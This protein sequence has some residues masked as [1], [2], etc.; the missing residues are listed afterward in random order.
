[1]FNPFPLYNDFIDNNVCM[2]LCSKKIQ[3]QFYVTL[4]YFNRNYIS[5]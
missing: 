1:M 5:Q 2:Y 3:F 4:T